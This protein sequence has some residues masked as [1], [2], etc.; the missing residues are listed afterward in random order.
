MRVVIALERFGAARAAVDLAAHP[1]DPNLRR[2][3][4]HAPEQID[5]ADARRKRCDRLLHLRLEAGAEVEHEPGALECR[6]GA[7]AQLQIVRFAVDRREIGDAH[8]VPADRARG[9]LERIE[10]G[11]HPDRLLARRRGR[12]A[13]AGR[14]GEGGQAERD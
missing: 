11:R 3:Q 14:G 12:R 6:E 7:R 10:A 13:A 8:A 9:L 2:P 1:R 4:R 5:A